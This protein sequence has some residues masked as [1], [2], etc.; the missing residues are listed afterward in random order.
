VEMA[1]LAAKRKRLK[2]SSSWKA[3]LLILFRLYFCELLVP[4]AEVAVGM[5]LC[6]IG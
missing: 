2:R 5:A 1:V 3:D 6:F 4:A